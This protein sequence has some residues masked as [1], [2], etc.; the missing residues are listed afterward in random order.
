MSIIVGAAQIMDRA[1]YLYYCEPVLAQVACKGLHDCTFTLACLW[2]LELQM[3]P[4]GCCSV[5]C[6]LGG[7]GDETAWFCS[8][9]SYLGNGGC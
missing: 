9:P 7:M 1:R 2:L 4:A 5:P 6:Y 8:V 3:E